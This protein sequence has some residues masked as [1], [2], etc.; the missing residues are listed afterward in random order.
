MGKFSL[1]IHSWNERL[2]QGGRAAW[3]LAGRRTRHKL[4]HARGWPCRL[5]RT[6]ATRL[7]SSQ[8]ELC[9]SER[10]SWTWAG[11]RTW[12][13]SSAFARRL[14][15]GGGGKSALPACASGEPHFGRC[16]G[17]DAQRSLPALHL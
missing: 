5:W 2:A 11:S 4:V 13:R 6:P 7:A 15:E 14:V 1:N 16:E 10:R 3:F 17:K 12:Q 8:A 9:T